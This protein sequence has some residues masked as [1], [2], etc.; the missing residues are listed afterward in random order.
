MAK[1]LQTAFQFFPEGTNTPS[2]SPTSYATPTLSKAQIDLIKPTEVATAEP[3]PV[4]TENEAQLTP[5]EAVEGEAPAAST[6]ETGDLP[7]SAVTPTVDPN[8][9]PTV[10]PSLTP[11]PTVYTTKLYGKD[12][13]EYYTN[14]KTLNIDR[15]DV[16]SVFKAQLLRQKLLDDV[17]KDLKPEAEQVWARH[18]LVATEDEANQ[19]L[20][21]LA[22]G[23]DWKELAATYSTDPGSKDNG[24]DLGWFSR[25][26]MVKPFEDAAFALKNVGD[27][28]EPIQSEH[29]WHIIQLIGHQVNPISS[30]E[31][32][33]EKETLFNNWLK[34]IRDSRSDITIFDV[35]KENTPTVPA[36]P[37]DMLSAMYGQ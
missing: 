25:G 17:T 10:Q 2:P 13:S 14:L 31:L 8:A 6:P 16:E 29:G 3:T 19:V 24:G 4:E 22:A 35:W 11:T 5:T 26:R 27:I 1:E 9:T 30:A 18:I 28:S 23:K 33:Q 7:E 15:K 12:I 36:V 37:S 32:L 21:E 20:E 34:E